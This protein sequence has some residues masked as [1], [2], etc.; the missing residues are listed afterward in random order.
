MET[1]CGTANIQM[2]SHFVGTE[3]FKAS[4]SRVSV[5]K[6]P[7]CLSSQQFPSSSFEVHTL[8]NNSKDTNP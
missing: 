5:L 7:R 8:T 2:Q 1:G 3:V 4:D 6:I